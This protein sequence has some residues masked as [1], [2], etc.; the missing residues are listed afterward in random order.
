[1]N[2]A[3]GLILV[4]GFVLPIGIGLGLGAYRAIQSPAF[5]GGA[6]TILFNAFIPILKEFVGGRNTPEIE[7]KMNE[8]IRRGGQWDNFHKKERLR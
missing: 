5:V 8:V 7:K 6:A 2:W 4:L 1:M 3:I